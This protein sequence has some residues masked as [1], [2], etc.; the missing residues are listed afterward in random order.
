MVFLAESNR[1]SLVLESLSKNV[2]KGVHT[3]KVVLNPITK[4]IANC[5]RFDLRH[6][7]EEESFAI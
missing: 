5:H 7:L 3:S 6:E 1:G 2:L 4:E